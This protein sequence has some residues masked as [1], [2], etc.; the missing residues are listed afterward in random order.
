VLSYRPP[1]SCK[2]PAP[3]VYNGPAEH[4]QRRVP[5]VT[6]VHARAPAAAHAEIPD[7]RPP[8]APVSAQPQAQRQSTPPHWQGGQAGGAGYAQ[9]PQ[10]RGVPASGAV[11]QPHW[12]AAPGQK[13][14]PPPQQPPPQQQQPQP[15]PFI[16]PERY[17]QPRGGGV[18]EELQLALHG[19]GISNS[20]YCGGISNSGYGGGGGGGGALAALQQQ[21]PQ[22]LPTAATYKQVMHQALDILSRDDFQS[23]G[24]GKRFIKS[25][26]PRQRL[27]RVAL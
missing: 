7:D 4:A 22:E 3:A 8:L 18:T 26:W 5:P 14:Q 24:G 6:S 15:P 27:A 17:D 13:A 20:G 10:W 25:Q 19:G 21:R 12:S 2:P 16:P 1:H 23:A 9:Q 11:Q